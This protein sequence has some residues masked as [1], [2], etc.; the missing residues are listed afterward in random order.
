MK[1]D[2]MDLGS[3][4]IHIIGSLTLQNEFLAYVVNKEIGAKC[5]IF[6][7]ELHSFSSNETDDISNNK[8][9]GLILIDT[10]DQSFE[11]ILKTTITNGDFS[12][13]LIALF[14][15]NENAGVERKALSLN[16]RG[17]F[18]KDDHFEIFLKGIRS[19]LSGEIWVP[20]KT[21]LTCVFESF[22]EKKTAIEEKTALTSREIEILTLV[23]MGS[24]NEEIANKMC[25]SPNTVKTHLYNIFKKINVEN[26]LQAALWAAA[27]I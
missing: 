16:I 21:L 13:Q 18:Y 8:D 19:I 5:S 25:I 4:K 10:E 24:T 27:N 15:L 2:N 9:N 23:S 7:R 1:S 17:F 3:S 6:D 12:S 14:N 22:D 20:R 11:E 26:R